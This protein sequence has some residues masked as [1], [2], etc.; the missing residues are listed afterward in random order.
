MNTMKRIA[1]LAGAALVL[2]ACGG[3][4]GGGPGTAMP[5]AP[6]AAEPVVVAGTK[7]IEQDDGGRYEGEVNEAGQPHGQGVYTW[8]D[9]SRYVGEWRDGKMQGQGA[10]TLAAPVFEPGPVAA[11]PA[12]VARDPAT[13]LQ[14]HDRLSLPEA[15]NAVQA[16]EAMFLL[17]NI[18]YSAQQGGGGEGLAA[19]SF[20]L[21]AGALALYAAE[22]TAA[23]TPDHAVMRGPW[24]ERVL[25]VNP[26]VVTVAQFGVYIGDDG[27][28]FSGCSPNRGECEIALPHPALQGTTTR[29]PDDHYYSGDRYASVSDPGALF[30]RAPFADMP[31]VGNAMREG[32]EGVRSRRGVDL[33]YWSSNGIVPW[34]RYR[35]KLAADEYAAETWSGY[36][37]WQ[38]WS[39]FG[40]IM[41]A[42]NHQWDLYDSAWHNH[43]AGGDMA[44]SLPSV[45][46]TMR[47]A[48]VAMAKDMRF[49]A[50]GDVELTVRLGEK[51]TLDV[52]IGDWQGYNLTDSGEI[53]RPTAVSIRAIDVGNIPIS[54]NGTF[55]TSG[56]SGHTRTLIGAFYGPEGVEAA[57]SFVMGSGFGANDGGYHGAFGVRKPKK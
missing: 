54:S 37:A 40:L 42:H 14:S 5:E 7:V 45:A 19:A 39:G 1:M 55:Q 10:E 13:L 12:D 41:L 21:Q 29:F 11:A 9:G 35:N 53:G 52:S 18:P 50:D 48:A 6:A 36:G 56:F 8:P 25:R 33:R 3:G 24:I 23:Y 20:T 26:E 57:G 27:Q 44:G 28:A 49:I 4:G 2:A 30:A 38:D 47:G 46:G 22:R 34:M 43:I 31:F 16:D 17:A 15:F 32:S 51:P